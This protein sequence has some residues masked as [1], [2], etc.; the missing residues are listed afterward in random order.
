[1]RRLV[2]AGTVAALA[3]AVLL[4]GGVAREATAPAAGPAPDRLVAHAFELQQRWR[5]TADPSNLTRSEAALRRALELE[6][7]NAQ[8]VFGLAS[9]ALSR[10]RFR[11][12]LALARRAQALDPGWAAPLG[13]IGDAQLELG[14]YEQAFEVFDEFAAREPGLASYSRIAYGR[15]LIGRPRGAIAAMEL[16]VGAAPLRGEPAAWPHVEL[17]KLH[18]G[19]GELR[20]AGRE[21]RLA[22]AAR[23]GFPSALDGLARVEGARGRLRAAIGLSRRAVDAVPLPQF[24]STLTDLYVAAGRPAEARRQL[25]LVGAIERLL[26]ANGVRTDLETAVFDVDHGLRFPDA[27]ARA[28][29]AY[30]ERP[31]IDAADALAWALVRNGQCAEGLTYSRRALSLGTLDAVKLF[32]LGMAERCAGREADARRTFRRALALNPHFSLRFAPLARRL[33]R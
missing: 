33:A 32:H 12:A 17:G 2:L 3:A 16:A 19:L 9:V 7:G 13:A 14:R 18:F 1:M 24:V 5:E 27:L 4:L 21:F 22:L 20:A 23:P 15:E 26:A 6:P 29:R 11:E 28:R 31:S 10:H 30:A 25:R 8:A